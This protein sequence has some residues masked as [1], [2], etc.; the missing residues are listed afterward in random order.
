M[1]LNKNNILFVSHLKSQCGIYEFWFNI[2]ESLK[3]SK[4]YDFIFVECWSMN[5]LLKAI[6]IYNPQAIIYNYHPSVMP[7]LSKKII[8]YFLY[9][10]NLPKIGIP[11][12]WIIHEVTQNLVNNIE[13]K[14]K[15]Y[16]GRLLSSQSINTLFDY[17]IAPDPTIKNKNDNIFVTWR[18]IPDYKNLFTPPI[19]PT[20][21]SFWFATWNKWFEKIVEKV[22]EEF[23]EAIIRLNIPFASFWDKSWENA[24]IISKNCKS[25]IQKKWIQLYITH[26]FFSKKEMLDFLAQN[27]INMFLY[28]NSWEEQ[29]WISSVIENALAVQRPICISHSSM[30]RHIWGADPSICIN[31]NSIKN[32]I[33]NWFSPLEQY[34]NAWSAQKIIFEYENIISSII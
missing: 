2:S 28:T 5:D 4:K 6:K 8:P 26:D 33:N 17:Y 24:K 11:Q 12:I 3:K 21:W 29:R 27:T 34:Y 25:L 9:K 22:Q 19:I 1:N 16:F 20:I 10:N 7:W 18:L 30:F 32:I 31:N 13:T 14:K 15:K 23:D